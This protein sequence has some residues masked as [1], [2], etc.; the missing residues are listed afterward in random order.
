[1]PRWEHFDHQ[2]D[3]GIRGFG[4]TKDEAFEQAALA[5]IAVIVARPQE[6]TTKQAVDVECESE[7]DAQLL[8]DW[9]GSLLTEMSA[10]RMVFRQFRVSISGRRLS[11]RA[12]GEPIDP[13]RHEPVVEVKGISYLGLSA[14]QAGPGL[15]VAQ[16]VVDV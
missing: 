14:V 5:L 4:R 2:A 11:A 10:R 12:Y 7:D 13:P 8:A 9:L 1:M 6:I 16:C 15:W 3:I